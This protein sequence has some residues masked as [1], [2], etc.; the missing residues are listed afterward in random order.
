MLHN[1]TWSDM[2]IIFEEAHYKFKIYTRENDFEPPHVHVF[3]DNESVCRLDLNS[4]RYIDEPPPG[5]YRAIREIY[6]R[7]AELIRR[8]WDRIHRR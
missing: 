1:D 5:N 8:E 3:V 6:K 2:P 4:G 7:N